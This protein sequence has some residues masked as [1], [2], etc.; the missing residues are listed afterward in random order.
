MKPFH[1]NLFED[2]PAFVKLCQ[3]VA[4]STDPQ[5]VFFADGETP[6][7][8][9]FLATPLYRAHLEVRV[10]ARQEEAIEKIE[11]AGLH[12]VRAGVSHW[13]SASPVFTAPLDTSAF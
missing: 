12:V 13:S 2:L 3:V 10:T 1:V 7:C 9:F 6:V 5:P 11:R 8:H 4:A